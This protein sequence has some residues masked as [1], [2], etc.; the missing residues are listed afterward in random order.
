[1]TTVMRCFACGNLTTV[2]PCPYCTKSP[3][4]RADWLRTHKGETMTDPTTT[5]NVTEFGPD[6][7]VCGVPY[8]AI[9]SNAVLDPMFVKAAELALSERDKRIADRWFEGPETRNACERQRQA[10][11]DALAGWLHAEHAEIALTHKLVVRTRVHGE[12]G[13]PAYRYVYVAPEKLR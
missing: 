6:Y 7:S 13:E 4:E 1:M 10:Q 3:A 11:A 8:A 5:E 2:Q 12:P 9:F